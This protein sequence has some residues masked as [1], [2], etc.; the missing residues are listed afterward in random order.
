LPVNLPI[1]FLNKIINSIAG[2]DYPSLSA[3]DS[4]ERRQ[5]NVPIKKRHDCIA[6]PNDMDQIGHAW[7]GILWAEGT[8][9]NSCLWTKPAAEESKI[10]RFYLH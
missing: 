4:G 10:G 5:E 1:N 6:R 7:C 3:N 8:D 2:I 9:D